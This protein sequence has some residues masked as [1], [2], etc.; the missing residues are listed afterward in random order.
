MK[1]SA[2]SK[3]AFVILT[4][5]AIAGFMSCKKKPACEKENF[6]TVIIVNHTG[7]DIW[8][9]C[10]AEGEDLNDERL[11]HQNDSTEYHMAPGQ[12]TEW[13]IEAWDYPSGSWYTDNYYLGQCDI[14]RDPWTD[15][16]SAVASSGKK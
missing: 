6:G 11:L 1:K 7:Q 16:K 4:L 3:T 12:I 15:E 8:V 2:L 13:A 14:H 9:D 10:T 5:L